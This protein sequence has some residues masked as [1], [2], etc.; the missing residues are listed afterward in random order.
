MKSFRGDDWM[1]SEKYKWWVVWE[2]TKTE[3][4][5]LITLGLHQAVDYDSFLCLY[6]LR[7]K[8]ETLLL[9]YKNL[10]GQL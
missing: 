9:T 8:F 5:W 4:N 6:H 2:F 1:K 3:A 10:K 7:N